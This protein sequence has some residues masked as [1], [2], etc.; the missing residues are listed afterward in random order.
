MKKKFWLIISLCLLMLSFMTNPVYAMNKSNWYK[1]VLNTKN[2]I[3]HVKCWGAI[4]RTEWVN[5]NKFHYYK[6]IDIN[7][8]GTKELLLSTMGTSSIVW[9]DQVLLLSYQNG[10]VVPVGLIAP[11]TVVELSC[12]GEY[13]CYYKRMAGFNGHDIYKFS[14]GKL[15]KVVS[16][17]YDNYTIKNG[18][19]TITY[20][21]NEKKCSEKIYKKYLKKYALGRKISYKRI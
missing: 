10:K 6:I 17:N 12:K 9:R 21:K 2:Q 11:A 15:K 16:L 4:N 7:K 20:R 8:D 1:T 13:L 19:Q 5:R 18:K 3:Y 14:N